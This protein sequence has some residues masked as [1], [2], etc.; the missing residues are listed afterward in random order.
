MTVTYSSKVAN[1]TFLSFHRLLLRWRGSIYKLLYREFLLFA[2]LY[3]VLSLVYRSHRTTADM[4]G[5][6]LQTSSFMDLWGG[7]FCQTGLLM[8][9]LRQESDGGRVGL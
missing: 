7:Q 1:A 2:L 5:G 4:G 6:M 9:P 8:Q 3:T